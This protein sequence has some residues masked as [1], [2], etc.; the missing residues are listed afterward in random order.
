M[1]YLQY[2]KIKEFVIDKIIDKLEQYKNISE[3]G[4]DLAYKLFEGEC[5]DGSYFYSNY[6]AEE[7]IK[8]NYNDLGEIMEELKFQ[9]GEKFLSSLLVDVFD[10]PD[11]VVVFVISEV[12]SYLLGQCETV[13]KYWN[14]EIELTKENI[15]NIQIELL[16]QS[17]EDRE[18]EI[19]EIK[20][21]G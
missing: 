2:N 18:K 17:E 3:Y 21:A 12:A 10:N 7:W 8:E 9:F 15:K 14:E 6:K 20:K 11:K 13:E 16:E 5:V 4:C 1:E 19:K